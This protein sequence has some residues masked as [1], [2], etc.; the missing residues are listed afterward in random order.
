MRPLTNA[1]QT[2]KLSEDGLQLALTNVWGQLAHVEPG[3]KD[4][5]V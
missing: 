1:R 3:C 2:T 4:G 5:G